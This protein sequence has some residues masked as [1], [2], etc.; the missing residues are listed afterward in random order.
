M[1]PQKTKQTK[2]IDDRIF[3]FK[4]EL[5]IESEEYTCKQVRNQKYGNKL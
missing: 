4:M 2:Y 5:K 1:C 3:N